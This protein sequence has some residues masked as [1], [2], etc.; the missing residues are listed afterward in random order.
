MLFKDVKII[1]LVSLMACLEAVAYL[2]IHTTQQFGEFTAGTAASL[3]AG[4]PVQQ[5]LRLPYNNA[6]A[7][8]V[9]F[10][11]YGE[12]HT[13]QID[14]QLIDQDGLV[15]ADTI[16]TTQIM[17]NHFYQFKFPLQTQSSSTPYQLTVTFRAQPTPGVV[18]PRVTPDT[19][20][21]IFY[22]IPQYTVQNIDKIKLLAQRINITHGGL[23]PAGVVYI[24]LATLLWM[25][26]LFFVQAWIKIRPN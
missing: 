17:G 24:L 7:L 20:P 23:V 13:G 4:E 25:G 12:T 11:S 8:V 10:G 9:F 15:Q 3:S 14:L 5:T 26:N 18:A 16:P 6:S 2:Y 21:E 19:P 22:V 1:V